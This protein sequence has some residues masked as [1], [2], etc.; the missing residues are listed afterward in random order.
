VRTVLWGN[1][2]LRGE[3]EQ[4]VPPLRVPF[5]TEGNTPVGMTKVVLPRV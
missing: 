3:R 2:A 4:Q 1:T 5:L